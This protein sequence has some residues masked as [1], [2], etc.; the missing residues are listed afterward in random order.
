M[1]DPIS[2]TVVN[3]TAKATTT[4]Q[5]AP[6][7]TLKQGPSKFDEVKQA[8]QT[9]AP[10]APQQIPELK[11]QLT[12]DQRKLVEAHLRKRIDS[13]G[14]ARSGSVSPQA[15]F[16]P[17]MKSARVQLDALHRKAQAIP[18]GPASDTLTDRLNSLDA[19]F[20][21]SGKVLEGMG[22][23]SSPGDMLKFQMQM[24]QFSQN[25]QLMSQVVEQMS[26]GAKQILQVQ[27]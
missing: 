6:T 26:S 10:A 3:Q 8:Q 20:Q 18:P 7:E 5:S 9:Q 19:Q 1:P 4:T 24:Y 11:T 17:D 21:D 12:V 27:V 14:G 13:S 2:S 25:M 15:I 22:N 16:K 23:V